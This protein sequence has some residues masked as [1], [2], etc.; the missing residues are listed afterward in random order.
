[1]VGEEGKTPPKVGN[2]LGSATPAAPSAGFSLAFLPTGR[3]AEAWP[4]WH[5]L[6]HEGIVLIE[7][8]VE[9]PG[10]SDS[11]SMPRI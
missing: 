10:W 6:R 9:G 1:M 4:R 3:A 2:L 8:R 5:K 7:L 11:K